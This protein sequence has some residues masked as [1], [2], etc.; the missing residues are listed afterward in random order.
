MVCRFSFLEE[1]QQGSW[2]FRVGRKFGA[3]GR[4]LK[5]S[6]CKRSF[7]WI[8]YDFKNLYCS[9][10]EPTA[11]ELAGTDM[12]DSQS[13]GGSSR[14]PTAN[15][16]L[17]IILPLHNVVGFVYGDSSR[18]YRLQETRGGCRPPPHL[19]FSL[20][21]KRQSLDLI[22]LNEPEI[23][24]WYLGLNSLLPFFPGRSFFTASEFTSLKET[25]KWDNF[26]RDGQSRHASNDGGDND[27]QSDDFNGEVDNVAMLPH[28]AHLYNED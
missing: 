21:T 24:R 18:A 23:E 6:F 14:R 2:F 17:A 27:G 15:K 19:C 11:T 20:W 9:A 28:F 8:S 22:A 5:S 3:I 16:E 7:V 13:G 26:R 10:S 1:M 25:L 4:A 12:L